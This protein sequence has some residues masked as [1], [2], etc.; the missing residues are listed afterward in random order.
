MGTLLKWLVERG[1]K[2]NQVSPGNLFVSGWRSGGLLVE[3]TVHDA[4]DPHAQFDGTILTEMDEVG[5]F[6]FSVIM[7]TV[8]VRIVK[9]K[10]IVFFGFG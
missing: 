2:I 7:G 3:H 6:K 1:M 10:G 5:E 4:V 9:S 8:Q